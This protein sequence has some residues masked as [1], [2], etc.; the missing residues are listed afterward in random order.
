VR[1]SK[2]VYK[3]K[4]SRNVYCV[5]I[6]AV[7]SALLLKILWR[8][9]CSG[10]LSGGA[11]DTAAFTARREAARSSPDGYRETISMLPAKP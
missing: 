2:R 8:P 5:N 4:V 6:D 7:I 11:L 10:A 3:A 1:W 9:Y